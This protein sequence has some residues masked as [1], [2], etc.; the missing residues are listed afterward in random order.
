MANPLG[1]FRSVAGAKRYFEIGAD[2]ISALNETR[3]AALDMWAG[4]APSEVW[5]R[6]TNTTGDTT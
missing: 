1:P 6:P 3:Q 2:G 4:L 5:S